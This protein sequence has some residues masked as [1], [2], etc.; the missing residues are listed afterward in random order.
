M[1]AVPPMSSHTLLLFL[2]QTGLLLA[3]AVGL[4]RLA[5]RLG[6]P[7]VAGELLAGVLLGPSILGQTAPGA[8]EWLFPRDP[9]Q[10]HLLDAVGQIGVLLLVG[11]TGAQMDLGLVRRRGRTAAYVSGASLVIPL[12]LGIAVGLALPVAFHGPAADRTAFALFLGVALCV[13]AIPVIAK[14]LTD[15]NLLHRNTGQLT[16]AA[17]MVDDIA[18]WLL[19]SV[20]SAMAASGAGV[21]RTA[22]SAACVVVVGLVAWL[23]V[24][25]VARTVLAR[26]DVAGEPP[27]ATGVV[28]LL[29]L[30]A[31][32]GTHA[33]GL[34]AVFGV[35][36][37]GMAI[38]ASGA[39][40]PALLAPLR[41]VVLGVLAPVFFATAGLRIDLS[42]L[43]S[44]AALGWALLVLLLAIVGKFVGAYLGAL[45]AGLNRWEAIALGAGLNARGVIEIVIATVG[46]RI[47][48]LSSRMYTIIV[49]VAVVTSLMA[50]PV[51]RWTMR[52][53]EQTAEE[54][55][56]AREFGLSREPAP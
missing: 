50:P 7:A 16:L 48:V 11:I 19:L 51:L 8:M 24:R 39:A 35:F 37:C 55:M 45:L 27:V 53:V 41:T 22:L 5:V 6:W 33:L 38:R 56:R 3:V 34:E 28:V 10:F 44:P 25:P 4:G 23:V 32:A 29:M 42:A 14:T 21:G 15:M 52:R 13:S 31:A 12:A 20:V 30:L 54:E 26:A 49:L 9:A 18:G 46:L 47:G 43:A 40:R 2:L 17:A 36:V 1:S